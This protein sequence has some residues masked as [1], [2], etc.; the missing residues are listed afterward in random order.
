MKHAMRAFSFAALILASAV[1]PSLA[2]E[3]WGIPGEKELILKGKV[4][5]LACELTKSCPPACGAGQRQLGVL[6]DAGRLVAVAKGNVD[7]AGAVRDIAPFCGKIIEMDGL[8]VES[9]GVSL[10]FVQRLRD[11]ASKDWV[12]ADRFKTEWEAKNGKAEEWFRADPEANRLIA[13]DGPLGIKGL[14]PKPKP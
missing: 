7:F 11:D 2:A 9:Q 6:T 10:Y 1:A 8:L 13:E 12:V 4:V 3:A 5:D 14:V